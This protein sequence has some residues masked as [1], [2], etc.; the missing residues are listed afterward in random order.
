MPESKRWY[1]SA[2]GFPSSLVLKTDA[3][4]DVKRTE[5]FHFAGKAQPSAD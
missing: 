3:S 2:V 5:D 1:Q 4:E